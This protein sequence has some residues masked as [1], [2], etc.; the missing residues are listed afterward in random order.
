[1]HYLYRKY[2]IMISHSMMLTILSDWA[3]VS[4]FYKLLLHI[5]VQEKI[6]ILSEKLER[7]S[8]VGDKQN[9]DFI[10]FDAA[11]KNS[12]VKCKLI[13]KIIHLFY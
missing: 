10:E 6:D 4:L 7:E 12:K 1:M 5:S 2:T 11:G 8:C 9:V 13:L 3:Y